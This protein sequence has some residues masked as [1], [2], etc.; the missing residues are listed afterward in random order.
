[1]SDSRP[2]KARTALQVAADAADC[3]IHDL[4]CKL[5]GFAVNYGCHDFAKAADLV[6]KARS[7][8][9]KH[10]HNDDRSATY[11]S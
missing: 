1:M 3:A 4:T 11:G 7:A 5:D 2:A 10:M 6:A 8:V 9:R